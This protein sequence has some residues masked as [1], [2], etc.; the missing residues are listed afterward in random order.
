VKVCYYLAS[1][2]SRPLQDYNM[3]L[4][5]APELQGVWFIKI[6][7]SHLKF[8]NLGENIQYMF[9]TNIFFI[10][11]NF[12]M[13]PTHKNKCVEQNRV[14]LLFYVKIYSLALTNS[15]EVS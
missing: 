11:I 4:F 5:I 15:S 13:S 8:R 10:E 12:R 6:K 3:G 14:C 9:S 2:T 7:I 1:R